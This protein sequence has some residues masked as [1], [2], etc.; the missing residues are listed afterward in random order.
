MPGPAPTRDQVVEL[1]EDFARLLELKGDN[2]FKI[3]AYRTAAAAI[4]TFPGDLAA[5]ALDG[6]IERTGGVGKAIAAK[7]GEWYASGR[8]AAL[9]ELREGLPRDILTLFELQGLGARKIKALHDEL[10]IG[11]ITALERACTDGR[12]AGLA[13]FGAKTAAN[14]LKAI[15]N[16]SRHLGYFLLRDAAPVAGRI[17]A[18]LKDH[19][20]VLHAEAAGS[21]RRRKEIVHD[22]DFVVASRDPASVIGGFAEMEGVE[23]VMARGETKC[24]VRLKEG[25][26][27]DLRVVSA[28]EYPFALSYFTGSKEHNVRLRQRALDRGWTLNEYRLAPAEGR[29]AVPIPEIRDEAALYRALDVEGIPPELREDRG[30]IEAAEQHAL[31]RLVEL[32][33]LRGVFHNHTDQSDGRN[34]LEEMAAAGAELGLDYLGIADHSRSS[35]QA[36]GLDA[37]RLLRQVDR[38]RELNRDPDLGIHLFAG[39]ECDILKDGSL[40]FPEEVLAQLDYVVASVHGSLTLSEADMTRRIVRAMESPF[41]TMLGHPTGRLLL[42]RDP[43]ALDIPAVIEAAAATGTII[44]LNANPRRLELDWR[45]WPLARKQGVRCSINPDAH[46]VEGLGHLWFGVAAARKGWLTRDDVVNCLPLDQIGPVLAAKRK[47]GGVG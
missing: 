33:N 24:S 4:E 18:F 37:G 40:D 15:D 14:L 42:S 45:W 13:G 27:C 29:E 19:P 21:Y 12:V 20:D 25:M 23:E 22:L 8:I 5:A 38:I 10:G 36:N 17:L 16:R 39:V 41:V 34:T 31:P 2:P 46:R 3:R 43:Y 7:L 47:R 26:Q 44:E 9:D 35:F 6:S 30:E 1:L 28:A 32:A 11:S